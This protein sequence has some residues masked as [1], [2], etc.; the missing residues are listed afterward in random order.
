M[1][2]TRRHCF[3]VAFVGLAAAICLQS[4]ALQAQSIE[5]QHYLLAQYQ[6]VSEDGISALDDYFSEALIPAAN[7]MGISPV[8]VFLAEAT[9]SAPQSMYL[10]LPAKDASILTTF[11]TK[12]SSDD[13]FTKAAAKYLERDV[14]S[15]L[16]SRIRSELLV[17]FDCLPELTVPKQTAGNKKRLFELR[18]YESATEGKGNRKVQMFNDGEVPIFI[19]SKIQPVFFGQAIVG[20]RVPNLTYLTVYDDSA[21]RDA[22]WK[23][24]MNL[25]SWKE[26][27]KQ[28]KYA[29][30]VSKIYKTDLK[31]RDYSQL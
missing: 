30:T 2:F 17:A 4:P 10:L 16:F 21:E 6:D 28:P 22:E 13:E 19:E 18:T 1:L 8:G 7:K 15:P 27:S 3:H 29:N 26:F 9:D 23:T 25:P 20:D 5:N 14:D 11:W 24:F 31:P 12:V